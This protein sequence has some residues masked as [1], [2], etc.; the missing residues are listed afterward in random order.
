MPGMLG[1]VPDPRQFHALCLSAPPVPP[2]ASTRLERHA[3]VGKVCGFGIFSIHDILVE[4]S[5]RTVT[6]PDETCAP[7]P[8]A[9][10][11]QAGEGSCAGRPS[12][13]TSIFGVRR[14]AAA[15]ER[16]LGTTKRCR[17]SLAGVKSH[18][19]DTPISAD[20]QDRY[21][22]GS[23][24]PH[25]NIYSV[26]TRRTLSINFARSLITAPLLGANKNSS[27]ALATS[28]MRTSSTKP[29]NRS[30]SAG[31]PARPMDHSALSAPLPKAVEPSAGRAVAA[32]STTWEF[33][34]PKNGRRLEPPTAGS[35][36]SAASHERVRLFRFQ[37]KQ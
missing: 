5:A 25:S 35:G 27:G 26:A 28:L 1:T 30:Q 8:L 13:H 11:P 31:S 7:S 22:S 24:A 20:H 18:R 23:E 19:R 15:L 32:R 2:G 3:L 29:Q 10:L 17:D 4:H 34:Q 12:G 21:Q 16:T 9:P 14:L 37:Q 6:M 33:T 36:Y